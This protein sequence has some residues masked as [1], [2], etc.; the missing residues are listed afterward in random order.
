M[1]PNLLLESLCR[2]NCFFQ[3]CLVESDKLVK[4]VQLKLKPEKQISVMCQIP[5]VLYSNHYRI[6]LDIS[7]AF[8]S[9]C[10]TLTIELNFC[11]WI[12]TW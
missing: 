5:M 8:G 7:D 10:L 1:L 4:N 12:S 9:L 2:I 3:I 11:T 6:R